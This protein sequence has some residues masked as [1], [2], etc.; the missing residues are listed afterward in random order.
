MIPQTVLMFASRIRM[1]MEILQYRL[2]SY[3]T[4]TLQ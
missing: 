2:L 1:I 4:Y 3:S